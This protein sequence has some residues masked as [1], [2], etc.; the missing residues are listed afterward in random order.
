MDTESVGNDA[1]AG[2][3]GSN[4]SKESEDGVAKTTVNFRISY[5]GAERATE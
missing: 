1:T 4:V 2:P 5:E 3:S